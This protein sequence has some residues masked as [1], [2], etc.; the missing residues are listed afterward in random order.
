[1]LKDHNKITKKTFENKI[2]HIR[3]QFNER[4]IELAMDGCR[5]I[6]DDNILLKESYVHS[7]YLIYKT[8]TIEPNKGD[9]FSSESQ[10]ADS[11]LRMSHLTNPK[12]PSVSQNMQLSLDNPKYKNYLNQF[13]ICT[14]CAFLVTDLRLKVKHLN[15]MVGYYK[16]LSLPS[17]EV[18]IIVFW[19]IDQN[20]EV[21]GYELLRE[22]ASK[23]KQIILLENRVKKMQNT[24]KKYEI[25]R[26][27]MEI[28]KR[29]Q[30]E[31]A[32]EAE[33]DRVRITVVS[34]K[35]YLKDLLND[36]SDDEKVEK[37][38]KEISSLKANEQALVNKLTSLTVINE[39]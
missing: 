22:N 16:A 26:D 23:T 12:L 3:K 5:G 14:T 24:I 21:K 2:M 27:A 31:K 28:H 15:E 7:K 37:L 30:I 34:I 6:N 32:V 33:I 11:I 38:I 9:N 19:A 13:S 35:E 25:D 18:D 29:V 1:M 20:A 10:L 8:Y 39:R 36:L 17:S 4:L